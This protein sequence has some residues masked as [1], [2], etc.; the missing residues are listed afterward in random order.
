V[1]IGATAGSASGR[2]AGFERTMTY[3]AGHGPRALGRAPPA[4]RETGGSSSAVDRVRPSREERA[5]SVVEKSIEVEVPVRTAYD[6]WTQFEEFPRFMEGV[7]EVVQV[8]QTTLRWKVDIM[9]AERS[10]ETKILTQEPDERIHWATEEGQDHEGEVRFE[11]AGG[12]TRVH[13]KMSYGPQNF[14]EKVGDALQIIDQRIEADLERFKDFI[15]QRG[16]E[17]GGWRGRIVGGEVVDD[18]GPS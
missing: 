18:G 16:D 1:S 14:T 12:R 9:G 2:P 7:D 17:T 4:G 6:Q 3:R 8:D 15:E 13:L 5:M 11:P 10:F